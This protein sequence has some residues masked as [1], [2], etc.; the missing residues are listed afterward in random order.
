MSISASPATLGLLAG[1][2]LILVAAVAYVSVH[3]TVTARKA[4]LA[5]LTT[6]V[7][8]WN[9]AASRWSSYVQLAQSH[10]AELADVKGLVQGRYPWEHLLTQLAGLMPSQSQLTNLTATTSSASTTPTAASTSAATTPGAAPASATAA[11]VPSIQL[12]GCAESQSM[13]AQTMDQLHRITGVTGVTLGS[14]TDTSAGSTGGSSAGNGCG[15]PVQFTVSLTFG[16]APTPG[17][18]TT[19]PSATGSSAA[20]SAA[21]KTGAS[22]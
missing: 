10:Q 11:P 5:Q 4:Q 6:G 22:S 9:A 16:A 7:S 8:E 18:G 14:T 2:V 21:P 13:V 12:T 20:S 15:F 3:N 1:L 19:A 17:T